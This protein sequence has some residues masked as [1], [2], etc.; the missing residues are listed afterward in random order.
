MNANAVDASAI[1]VVISMQRPLKIY[2]ATTI[3][4]VDCNL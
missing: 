2:I 4:V 3:A 1:V